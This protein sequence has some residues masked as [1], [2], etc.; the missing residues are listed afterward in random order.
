[1]GPSAF[2]GNIGAKGDGL[3]GLKDF[4]GPSETRGIN[5]SKGDIIGGYAGVIIAGP[6]PSHKSVQARKVGHDAACS[7]CEHLLWM[8]QGKQRSG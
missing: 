5:G 1:M 8:N 7:G 2:L 6:F 3:Y 4:M